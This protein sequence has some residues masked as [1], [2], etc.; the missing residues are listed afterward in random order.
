MP[1]TA[2]ADRSKIVNDL[3]EVFGAGEG[4]QTIDPKLNKIAGIVF[5][6]IPQPYY[7]IDLIIFLLTAYPTFR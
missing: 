7:H 4:I 5:G 6:G 3:S 1:D 2:P